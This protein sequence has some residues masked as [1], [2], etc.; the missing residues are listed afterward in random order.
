MVI[1]YQVEGHT[2]Y[3]GVDQFENEDL[4]K[5]SGRF[6][7]LTN[8]VL[9]WYHVDKFSSPHAYIRLDEGETTAPPSLAAVACQIVKDGSIDG[10]KKA[11]VDVV[12]TAASN[13]AKKKG[14]N[15]GQVSF[16]NRAVVGVEHGVRKDTKI[17]NQLE[18]I[19]SSITLAE[20][21]ADLQDLAAAKKKPKPPPKGK[22]P[23]WGDDDWDEPAPKKPPPKTATMFGDLPK[24]EFNP[25]MEDDFM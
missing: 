2:I 11:A 21:E 3:V 4:I 24:A 15:P 6:M 25:N 16:H 12:Y 19:K 9:V 13:L 17:L 20:M 18:K 8:L 14:M 7:E 1:L 5:F 10:T 23:D 22:D